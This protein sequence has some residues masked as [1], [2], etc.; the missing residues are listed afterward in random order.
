MKN[1]GK[2]AHVH[3]MFI[4]QFSENFD[5]AD[6]EEQRRCNIDPECDRRNAK[7]SESQCWYDDNKLLETAKLDLQIRT[8]PNENSSGD[9]LKSQT[10]GSNQFSPAARLLLQSFFACE[11]G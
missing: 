8:L 1:R 10:N 5:E 4:R 2:A 11:A 7:G 6:D 3:T 9:I